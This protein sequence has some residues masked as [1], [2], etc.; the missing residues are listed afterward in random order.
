MRLPPA[1]TRTAMFER[2]LVATD[3]SALSE[4]AVDSAIDLAAQYRAELVALRLVPRQAANYYDGVSAYD[5]LEIARA[6]S[7]SLQIARAAMQALVARAEARDVR[8]H[9]D[10]VISDMVCET[11]CAAATRHHSDLIVMASNERGSLARLLHGSNTQDVM[12]HSR[13]P[14]LVVR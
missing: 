13:L 3:G 2:I 14:V 6:E 4:R 5:P 9:A 10:T 7:A 11:I 8:V 12:T 1:S